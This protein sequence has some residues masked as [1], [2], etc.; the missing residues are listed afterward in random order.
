MR[1]QLCSCRALH[2]L[3]SYITRS[4]PALAVG[5]RRVRFSR[6][7]FSSRRSINLT[8]LAAFALLVSSDTRSDP[9]F[10]LR[11]SSSPLCQLTLV[12]TSSTV[13]LTFCSLSSIFLKPKLRNILI[14]SSCTSRDTSALFFRFSR[15]FVI[16]T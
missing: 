7:H 9:C 5:K 12:L 10:V 11:S 14:Q 15:D 6:F 3:P 2:E 8:I 1:Y 16:L 13:I 4:F